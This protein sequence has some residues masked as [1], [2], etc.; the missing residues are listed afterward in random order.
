MTNF[1]I[2]LF[3]NFETL[4]AFGPAEIIGKLSEDYMLGYYSLHG[5]I[6][7]SNQKIQVN[8]LPISE[9][10]T[11]GILLIPGGMET[12]DRKSTRLNSSH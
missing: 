10:N 1:N 4:D 3:H 5:G 12:R 9:I 7:E 11:C 6:V 8:T 2:L